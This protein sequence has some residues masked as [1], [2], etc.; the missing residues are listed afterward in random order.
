MIK[1]LTICLISEDFC[2]HMSHR[3]LH[4]KPIY[5]YVHK[6]HHE[7]KHP[8][9]IS[10]DYVHPLEFV[11]SGMLPSFSGLLLLGNKIHLWTI[12][13]WGVFRFIEAHDGHCGYE[14]PWSIFRLMPFNC[15][16]TYHNFHHTNN[17]GNYSSF[18]TIWDTVFNSNYEFYKFYG[19]GSRNINSDKI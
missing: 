19:K 10:G 12:M 8:I 2:F 7:F 18:M 14:F 17:V 13:V 15:D 5:R 9:S 3:I 6:W 4:F 1:H 11:C 16:A